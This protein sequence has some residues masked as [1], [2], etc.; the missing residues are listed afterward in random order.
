ME[1]SRGR[2]RKKLEIVPWDPAQRLSYNVGNVGDDYRW[3]G[4]S[5]TYDCNI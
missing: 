2:R 5:A 4:S 1:V 3:V